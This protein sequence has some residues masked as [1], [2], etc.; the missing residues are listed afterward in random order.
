MSDQDREVV[1]NQFPF[2]L[3]DES[4]LQSD[5]LSAQSGVARFGRVLLVGR[6]LPKSLRFHPEIGRESVSQ[7]QTLHVLNLLLGNRDSHLVCAM[8]KAIYQLTR[9]SE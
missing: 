2:V 5:S 9:N 8:G 6:A 7:Q 1:L 3:A 4:V